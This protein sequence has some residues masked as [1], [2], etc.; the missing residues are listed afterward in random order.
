MTLFL[1]VSREE[2]TSSKPSKKDTFLGA[3]FISPFHDFVR[4]SIPAYEPFQIHSF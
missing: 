1:Y 4:F 3:F 2:E